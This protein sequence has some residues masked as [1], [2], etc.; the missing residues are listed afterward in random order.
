MPETP[1]PETA[2]PETPAPPPE[3]TSEQMAERANR[4]YLDIIN[5]QRGSNH[6]IVERAIAVGAKLIYCK[7]KVGHGN[8]VP[9]VGWTNRRFAV[10]DLARVFQFSRIW[11]RPSIRQ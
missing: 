9:W 8:W 3:P 2:K 5:D 10:L 6:K 7:S 4:E 1:K 11:S